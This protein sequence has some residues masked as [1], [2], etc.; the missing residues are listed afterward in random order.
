MLFLYMALPRNKRMFCFVGCRKKKE[1]IK[2]QIKKGAKQLRAANTPPPYKQGRTTSKS[3]YCMAH[4]Q[5][6]RTCKR[7]ATLHHTTPVR[8]LCVQVGAAA[9]FPHGG[10]AAVL[11]VVFTRTS[12]HTHEKRQ[13]KR[14]NINSSSFLRSIP[15][16]SDTFA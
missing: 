7:V 14:H 11:R 3:K 2:R 13:Q 12:T 4:E 8:Q 1:K 9:S 10:A 15:R 5:R 16:E 6:R